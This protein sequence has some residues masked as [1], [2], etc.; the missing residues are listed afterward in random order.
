[1]KEIVDLAAVA[2]VPF[3]VG[4]QRR[5]DKNFRRMKK[6]I[7]SGEIG[8]PRVIRCTSRDNPIPPMSYLQTS[9]GIFHDM[10]S[11]DFDMIHYLTGQIP[12]E[13]YSVGHCYDDRIA[14]M[15]DADTVIVTMKF[16]SGLM[17][18]VDT[19]RIASYGY[20]QRVEVFGDKGM[21]NTRNEHEDTVELANCRGHITPVA[22]WSFPQ[23]YK[24]TYTI[25]LAE[26]CAMVRSTPM[27]IEEEEIVSRHIPL[28][29]VA[30]AAELSWKLN[31]TVKL[32][33]V[34]SLRHHLNHVYN[35]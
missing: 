10:L 15:N 24:H 28:E 32:A 16:K 11:H 33:E 2:Q 26:F 17:A 21:V 34:D 23:R 14:K 3:I 7:D 29:A 18:T 31:R 25:E 19:S 5:C 6:L 8:D 12:E 22:E 27:V 35:H 20:D 1:V 30:T 9:G 4:F 13:V